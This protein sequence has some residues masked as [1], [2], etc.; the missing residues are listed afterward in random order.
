MCVCVTEIV[1]LFAC[2][3]CMLPCSCCCTPL[4]VCVRVHVHVRVCVCVCVFV[5]I[6]WSDRLRIDRLAY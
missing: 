4:C 1:R 6:R 5:Q 2:L 3:S